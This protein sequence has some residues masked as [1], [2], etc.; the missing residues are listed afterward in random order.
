LDEV[1][2]YIPNGAALD[3]ILVGYYDSRDLM[4][5]ASVRAGLSIEWRLIC[6]LKQ[7]GLVP[8]VQVVRSVELL[9]AILCRS[10]A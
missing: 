4:Y 10:F 6:L 3:S 5:A 1:A 7:D 2:G 8:H 9:A